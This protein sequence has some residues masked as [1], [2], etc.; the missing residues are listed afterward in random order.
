M[1]YHDISAK[2]SDADCR[3]SKPALDTMRQKLPFLDTLTPAERRR[4]YKMGDRSL[5]FVLNRLQAA[6]NNAGVLLASFD[7]PGF[8]R[9]VRLAVALKELLGAF[10][11]MTSRLDGTL[12]GMGSEAMN[13]ATEVYGYVQAAARKTPGLKP[14]AVQLGERFK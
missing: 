1:P 10:R 4:L 8:E 2:V 6:K 9:D 7:L 5:A 12:L 3:P 14:V 11:Q 13:A